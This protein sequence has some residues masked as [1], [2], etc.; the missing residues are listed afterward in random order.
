MA[1]VPLLAG[2]LGKILGL[3]T[4]VM[5]APDSALVRAFNSISEWS[6]A[7]GVI[8]LCVVV[9]ARALTESKLGGRR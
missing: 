1:L 8:S 9:L 2:I 3:M 5:S 7:I 4:P 6:L